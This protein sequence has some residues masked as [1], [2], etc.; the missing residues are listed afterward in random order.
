MDSNLVKRDQFNISPQG[1]VHK[2]TDAAFTPYPGDPLS[3]TTRLGTGRP[4]RV[5]ANSSNSAADDAGAVDRVNR[6]TDIDFISSHM[7][8]AAARIRPEV[9]NPFC[10]RIRNRGVRIGWP[11]FDVDPSR[12]YQQKSTR[13][14]ERTI[15]REELEPATRPL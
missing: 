10:R 7:R 15:F 1:I 8:S 2:P 11:P 14:Q 12:R 6:T 13:I 5:S 4:I 9:Q 3:G